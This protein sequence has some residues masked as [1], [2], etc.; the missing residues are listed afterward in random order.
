M[1]HADAERCVSAPAR[2]GQ[3]TEKTKDFSAKPRGCHET[4]V[5]GGAGGIR[6]LETVSRL[7]TFQAC[8]FDHS[9]TA[10]SGGFLAAP[11]CGGKAGQTL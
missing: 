5:G 6:T 9:A 4:G 10:P 11:R 1:G 8:A 2:G 7:H 3:A